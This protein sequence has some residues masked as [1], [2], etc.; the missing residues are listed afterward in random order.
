MRRYPGLFGK[1]LRAFAA[2]MFKSPE[3]GCQTIVYCAVT[4]GLRE[5]SGKFFENCRVVPTKD[6]VRDKAV[7]KKL[8]LLSLHLC[9][10]DETHPENKSQSA[11]PNSLPNSETEEGSV[12]RRHMVNETNSL[13]DR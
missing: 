5:E 3:D 9:G 6:Y 4:D 13:S 10:L 7:C 1:F 12:N 8:W 11:A 2:F